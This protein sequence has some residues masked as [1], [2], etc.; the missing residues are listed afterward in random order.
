MKKIT[1]ALLSVSNKSGIIELA[2]GLADLGIEI[3]S[4][5]GTAKI[6]KNHNVKVIDVSEVT[7]FPEILDG[8]VKTLHPKVHGGI[9]AKRD[10]L[11]HQTTIKDQS[12]SYIDL[13]V[14]NL[15]PFSETISK[16]GVSFDEAIENIDIGGPTMIRAAA[17]NHQDVVV[18]VDTKDYQKI[19]T[20]LKE[21]NAQI[22]QKTKQRL[23]TKAFAHTA[24][25][26]LAIANYLTQLTDEK[27]D[28]FTGS[29]TD[30]MPKHLVLSL[31]QRQSLRYGENPHQMAALYADS[32]SLETGVAT[33]NQLQGKELSYNNFLD[34]DAAWTLVSEFSEISCV[35]IKHTNPC[36]VAFGR[37]P[38]EAFELAKATDPLSAFGG[39]IAFNVAVDKET[40]LAMSDLFV[41]AIIAP[42]FLEEAKEVF[43]AKKNLRLLRKS[44]S[45]NPKEKIANL[46]E[47]KHISG[48]Y[49]LQTKDTFQV[50][51]ENTKV[52]TKLQPT[53]EQ[54]A[55]LDFAWKICK[56]VKSNAIVY[57]RQGQLVGVGAGQMSRIDSVRFGATKAQLSLNECVMASDAFFP[58]RDSIDQAKKYGI[59]AII[60][61]G[62]SIRDTEVIAAADEL[63]LAM[64]FTEIRHFKH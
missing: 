36:G 48:G 25:Y 28:I 64:V 62:G 26:D 63:G 22:S 23:A 14:V 21:N 58:F 29:V 16:E 30:Q 27:N 34:L 17:K 7:G 56:H 13:V 8:R 53:E 18:V 19:L 31:S 24:T 61:P 54:W 6:L 15:Y 12:I 46:L 55:A 60:Q 38:K 51:R 3:I 52:V 35:I 49:L 45:V 44:T 11:E 1:R 32:L 5:G 9:L 57:A 2:Q 47:I 10:D 42:D 20:E 39:I 50:L 41:E 33:A 59:N 4:T 43:T 37:T 40:A